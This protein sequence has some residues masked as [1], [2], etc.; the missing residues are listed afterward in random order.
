MSKFLARVPGTLGPHHVGARDDVVAQNV[1]YVLS[2]APT[3]RLISGRALDIGRIQTIVV[4]QV[5]IGLEGGADIGPIAQADVLP[6]IRGRAGV[7]RVVP[8]IRPRLSVGVHAVDKPVFGWQAARSPLQIDDGQVLLRQGQAGPI[9]RE[10]HRPQALSDSTHVNVV[11]R[12]IGAGGTG[13]VRAVRRVQ[14][15]AIE[16]SAREY[17]VRRISGLDNDRCRDRPGLK[18]HEARERCRDGHRDD[19]A[20]PQKRVSRG[21]SICPRFLLHPRLIPTSASRIFTLFKA[22]FIAFNQP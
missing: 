10:V 22:F 19:G 20:L 8:R 16:R 14:P 9:R 1:Q 17:V 5:E 2:V 21:R 15:G 13:V 6:A 18:K 11:E 12:R 3:T 4:D 7:D